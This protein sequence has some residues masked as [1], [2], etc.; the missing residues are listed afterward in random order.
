[1]F[2][3]NGEGYDY[4][5]DPLGARGAQDRETLAQCKTDPKELL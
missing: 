3:S 4:T 1:L 5:W 2:E